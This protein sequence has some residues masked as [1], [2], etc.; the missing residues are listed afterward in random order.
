MASGALAEG[1]AEIDELSVLADPAAWR[2]VECRLVRRD[3]L[4]WWRSEREGRDDVD[5]GVEGVRS[6]R[7]ASSGGE[8]AH[9]RSVDMRVN[10]V[11]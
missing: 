2:K 7:E 9:L 4:A 1:S 5:A 3:D 10:A 6:A 11:E 8:G